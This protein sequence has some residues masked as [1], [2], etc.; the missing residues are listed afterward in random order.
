[1]VSLHRPEFI[2]CPLLDAEDRPAAHVAAD[3]DQHGGHELV[4]VGRLTEPESEQAGK[5][6]G[7]QFADELGNVER[8]GRA[9]FDLPDEIH[10]AAQGGKAKHPQVG[11]H[12]VIAGILLGHDSFLPAFY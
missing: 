1:M 12:R 6:A 4:Q 7:D 5:A 2:F 9:F 8:P 10:G 11:D 3:S